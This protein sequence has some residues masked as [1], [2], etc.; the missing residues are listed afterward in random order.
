VP[1]PTA[2]TSPLSGFSLAESG[3][4]IPHAV[5]SSDAAG[6]IKTLSANGLM[7]ILFIFY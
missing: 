1:L 3:R 2:I 5:F 7:F 4:M 6:L